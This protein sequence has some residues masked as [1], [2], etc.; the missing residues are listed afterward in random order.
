LGFTPP[1]QGGG[2]RLTN[3]SSNVRIQPAENNVAV[4]ELR[5]LALADNHLGDVLADGRGLLP[6]HGIAVLLAGGPRGG[7]DGVELERGV[8]REEEDEALAD[9]AG[10]A[11]DAW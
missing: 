6:P 2:K 3:L 9:R 7:A 10:A 4:L 11:E 5:G 8:L 1:V